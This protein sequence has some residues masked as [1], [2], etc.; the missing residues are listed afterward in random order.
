MLILQEILAIN[1][2]ILTPRDAIDKV[3]YRQHHFS[4]HRTLSFAITII[5]DQIK[6]WQ[7][8][9]SHSGRKR[10]MHPPPRPADSQKG[11]HLSKPGSPV[12]EII[13]SGPPP[14]FSTALD[15]GLRNVVDTREPPKEPP[16]GFAEALQAGLGKLL[17]D[18]GVNLP[19]KQ[20]KQEEKEEE[21]R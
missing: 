8:L 21:V 19:A 18:T 2:K 20:G 6:A 9:L 15:A 4:A 11:T 13:P 1:T 14:R 5:I 16:P 12:D 17:E 3:T 10:A 7:L